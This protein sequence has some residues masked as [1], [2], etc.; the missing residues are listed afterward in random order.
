L[1]A[2]DSAFPGDF[3]RVIAAARLQDGRIV[4][5]D[6][7]DRLVVFD[8]P[9]RYAATVTRGG[10]GLGEFLAV[11]WLDALPGDSLLVWDGYAYRVSLFDSGLELP[12]SVDLV[13]NRPPSV[14]GRFADGTWLAY[15]LVD[16]EPPG[17][18][19][20]YQID[21][22]RLDR[23]GQFLNDIATVPGGEGYDGGQGSR[24][25]SGPSIYTGSPLK[26]TSLIAGPDRVYVAIGTTME[27]LMYGMD[28]SE[29]G[30]FAQPATL[31]ETTAQ[32]IDQLSWSV[33][34]ANTLRGNLPSNHTLPAISQ[35]MLDDLGNV[36]VGR[37]NRDV[38]EASEW[39]VFDE[40]GRMIAT[41]SIPAGLIPRHVGLDFVVGVWK[42]ETGA[43]WV[44][45]HRL[46]RNAPPVFG[47][48]AP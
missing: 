9:G 1:G 36:W 40:E 35:M 11:Q 18:Y 48:R 19:F 30:S 38:N 22:F 6:A 47:A 39:L 28:G 8:A 10:Q 13:G 44:R 29:L 46:N 15:E 17:G 27:V 24:F 31:T 5:A 45:V 26:R 32:D 25:L 14:V 20:T 2:A 41:T 3:Y 23:D 33:Q 16:M 42:D 4:V 37:F 34:M 7:H 12:T 43:E 21:L